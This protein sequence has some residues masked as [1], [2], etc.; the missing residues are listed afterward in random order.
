MLK[1]PKHFLRRVNILHFSL[2]AKNMNGAG[3]NNVKGEG[4]L[5]MKMLDAVID[6]INLF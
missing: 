6:F 2:C 5:C 1:P 3:I 4:P